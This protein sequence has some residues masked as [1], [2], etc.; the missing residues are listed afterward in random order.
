MENQQQNILWS[1][2]KL[3]MKSLFAPEFTAY[4]TNL[5]KFNIK[6]GRIETRLY[7]KDGNIFYHSLET[8]FKQ[9]SYDYCKLVEYNSRAVMIGVRH[10]ILLD[11][12]HRKDLSIYMGSDA[13][14]NYL[15]IKKIK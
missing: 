4:V 9:W 13:F 14:G 10:M 5:V 8:L 11:L 3:K 7:E 12:E 2:F 15:A 6:H 1:L